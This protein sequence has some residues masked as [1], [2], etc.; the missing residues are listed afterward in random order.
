MLLLKY[1]VVYRAVNDV[2]P[3]SITSKWPNIRLML[4]QKSMVALL[5]VT[6][7][8]SCGWEAG[9]SVGQ[10]NDMSRVYLAVKSRRVVTRYLNAF[11]TEKT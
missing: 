1:N 3:R 10:A 9:R 7:K 6:S 5:R 4:H 8:V 11:I 2:G